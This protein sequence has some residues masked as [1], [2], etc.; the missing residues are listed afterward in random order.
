M[1]T[2]DNDRLNLKS[3]GKYN[4]LTLE[5]VTCKLL[6][7]KRPTIS[8]FFQFR[9]VCGIFCLNYLAPLSMPK[10]PYFFFD[11]KFMLLV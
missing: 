6:L 9:F 3:A 5:I 2:H 4:M 11:L 8:Q 1:T 7:L 10:R